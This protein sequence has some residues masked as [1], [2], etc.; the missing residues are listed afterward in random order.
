MGD[1]RVIVVTGA[2]GQQGGAALR[3]LQGKGWTLRAL[4]RDP[5]K[6]AAQRLP[7]PDTEVV[8]A[9][10]DDR[11]SLDRALAG[12]YGLFG[13]LTPR[14][15][16]PAGEERQGK[17]LADAAQAA[18]VQ[19]VVYSSVGGA[20]KHTG[21]PHFDSKWH[22]EEHARGLGLPLT[23]L[24]PVFFMENFLSYSGPRDGAV[25]L[26]LPS[27]RPLQLIA[28]DDIGAF[29]ALA[30]ARP[31]TFLGQALEIA[32]DERTPS[33]VAASWSRISGQPVR[34]QELPLDV[35]RQQSVETATMFDWLQR[36]GYQ[37]DIPALRRLYPPLQ[38]FET[39]LEGRLGAGA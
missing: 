16:G 32:G 1:G 38:S 20:D 3:H 37:A 34:F 10:P 28:V 26:P 18:G 6:P 12:A 27:D 35:V 4:T 17:T 2:T 7:A 24:R 13:V 39:W 5:A 31:A 8:A 29:A 21:I 33:Q 36:V 23:V 25:A 19:H 22:I 14:E 11:A 30:F 9:N 15:E